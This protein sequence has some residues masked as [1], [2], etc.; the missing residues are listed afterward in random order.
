MQMASEKTLD[1]RYGDEILTNN[2]VLNHYA[3]CKE[4]MFRDKTTVNG[5]ECGWNKCYCL[6]FYA[7]ESK[8]DYVYDNAEEC[9]C[10]DKI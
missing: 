10:F 9:E 1:K 4:C 8:P 7:P 2:A 5:K 6:I 3:Q